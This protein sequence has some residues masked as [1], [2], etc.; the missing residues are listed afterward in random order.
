MTDRYQQFSTTGVG[1]ALV[2]RLGLPNPT[3]LRRHRPGEPPLPGPALLGAAPGGRLLEQVG[4]VLKAAGAEVLTDPPPA[5]PTYGALVFDATGITSPE[6]L[7]ALYDFFHPVI[8]SVAGSGRV[9][10]LGTPPQS[11]GEPGAVIAQRALEGFVRSVGKELKRGATAQLVYVAD[12][13]EDKAESTL[14]FLL[15][16]K[17]AYVD[18]QVIR[19]GGHG[20]DAPDPQDWAAP[21]TGKVALVTGASRGIGA[22]IAEVLAR[23]GAK[24]VLLDIPAQGA[25]LARVANEVG[26]LALQLDITAAEAPTTLAEFLTQRHGGVDIVVHNAG[27][28]R[29]KTLAKMKDSA[30]ESVVQVN[31]AAQLRVNDALLESGALRAGGRVI[32]V[33]SIAGIAGNVGQTNYA[34]SKA[35]VIGMVEAYAPLYA[36][37][38]I[39]I[40][41]VAPGFIETRM[42]AAVPLVIREAGRRMNS[43]SQGG[44]PVDVAET[45]AWFA[46]PASGAVSGNVVR[47]CGQSLLG[48]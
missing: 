6:G 4:A 42:T 34:V 21:L 10:V 48:A 23:D 3:P 32:G 44:L 40:N 20:G 29:D 27:I 2:K 37:K 7:R 31:L 45:I 25:D 17:S 19:V 28:T 16:A 46:A 9:V 1:K 13:H 18:A 24:V 47:V 41:A 12:G 8:R 36:E 11:A 43:M 35:G 33:S 30:W 22:A 26:G 14:R 39:T 38:G 5:G 15:S